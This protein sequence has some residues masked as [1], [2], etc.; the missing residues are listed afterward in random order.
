[1]HFD[2]S[3]SI[4]LCPLKTRRFEHDI[5]PYLIK[6]EHWQNWK[7]LKENKD[8]ENKY[9]DVNVKWGYWILSQ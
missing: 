3:L 9:I 4:L 6:L 2:F 1:M 7:I 8:Y 5:F